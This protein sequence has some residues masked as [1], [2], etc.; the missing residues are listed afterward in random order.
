MTKIEFKVE[1]MV[2]QNCTARIERVM[3]ETEGVQSVVCDIGAKSISVEST[4]DRDDV[5]EIIEDMGFD[6]VG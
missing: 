2:C 1:G 3:G 6:V 5:K 4:M